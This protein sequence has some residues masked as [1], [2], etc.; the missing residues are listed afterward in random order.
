MN[1]KKINIFKN[2]DAKELE[3]ISY[4][5][6]RYKHDEYIAFRGDIV[7]G[8][9]VLYSGKLKTE[10][11]AANG[12]ARLIQILDNY[13]ILAPAFIFSQNNFFP[14]D[15]IAI[16]EV[17]IIYIKKEDFFKLLMTNKTILENFLAE[18]SSKVQ[19][20]SMKLW[21]NYNNKTI[22]DKL[23]TYIYNK[24]N[25][26]DEFYIE[27]ISK[28]AEV[29]QVARGSL[30]RVLNS[31]IQEKIIEKQG[32]KYILKNKNYLDC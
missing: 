5:V 1:L 16:G 6:K 19:T 17:E 7:D 31:L 25:K 27:N 20:L 18:I 14:V 13:D 12:V 29:F 26:D 23:K 10:M 11:L 8:F 30:S 21:N 24:I 32:K 15:I 9:Y 22:D 28:L 4:S 3:K 2:L